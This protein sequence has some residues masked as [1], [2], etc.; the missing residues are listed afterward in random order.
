MPREG[1][2]SLNPPHLQQS[3]PP[4]LRGSGLRRGVQSDLGRKWVLQWVPEGE[5]EAA[6]NLC[7]ASRQRPG[8][9]KP[10]LCE[11]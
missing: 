10:V 4:R 2:G 9:A 3:L 7:T 1:K 8:L 11:C 5:G 6:G